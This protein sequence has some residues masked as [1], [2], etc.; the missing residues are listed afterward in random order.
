MDKKALK[1]SQKCSKL[2]EGLSINS[3]KKAFSAALSGRIIRI[4]GEPEILVFMGDVEDHVLVRDF[5]CNCKDFQIN[6]LIQKKRKACY[7]LLAACIASEKNKIAFFSFDEVL[8][9]L[10]VREIISNGKTITLRRILKRGQENGETE[11]EET[12]SKKGC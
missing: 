2:S 11:K 10:I 9:R 7:H 8:A 3:V 1:V 5:Y 4:Y 12:D 6:A